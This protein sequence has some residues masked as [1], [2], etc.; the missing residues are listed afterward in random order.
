MWCW[1]PVGDIEASSLPW[2]VVWMSRSTINT[3]SFF[4][5]PRFKNL[6]FPTS[7]FMRQS[8]SDALCVS[9]CSTSR[10]WVIARDGPRQWEMWETSPAK[11]TLMTL[12][13]AGASFVYSI[14]RVEESTL[15]WGTPQ[16]ILKQSPR[17]VSSLSFHPRNCI[18]A[19]RGWQV[20]RGSRSC[21]SI[22]G[23]RFYQKPW[24]YPSGPRGTDRRLICCVLLVLWLKRRL[25][26][27]PVSYGNRTTVGFV[28]LRISSGFSACNL[29][30]V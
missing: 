23:A 21:T 3:V 12:A 14:N 20:G 11:E 2:L 13:T 7:L 8:C 19:V 27:Y 26:L 25:E 30:G 5:A 6:N 28:C 4:L 24:W 10:L 16:L 22:L 18:T 1:A 29:W 9:I 15:Q 17:K